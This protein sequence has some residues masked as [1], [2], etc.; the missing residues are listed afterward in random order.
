[1]AA[2]L[3]KTHQ[4]DIREKIKVSQIINRLQDNLDGKIELNT[5]QIQ[6]ARIL[7]DKTMSNA[8]QLVAQTTEHSGEIKQRVEVH[9]VDHKG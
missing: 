9:I 8:P 4:D 1:M 3:R 2:R 6:S 7:L 5:G